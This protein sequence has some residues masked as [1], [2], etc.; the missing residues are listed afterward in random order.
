MFAFLRKQKPAQKHAQPF[1][2]GYTAE[3]FRS[4]QGLVSLADE[5][6]RSGLGG[7][8]FAALH[9]GLPYGYP[10]RGQEANPT[11]A[12]IELGRTQGYMDCLN[13][14]HLL[15]TPQPIPKEVEQDYGAEEFDELK[16]MKV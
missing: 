14:L 15:C 4:N 5:F 16:D 11:T 7:H 2:I 9:N 3:E 6:R 13:L 1:P 8:I 10:M 12:S